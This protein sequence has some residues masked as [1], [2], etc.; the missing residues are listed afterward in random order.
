[1]EE[2]LQNFIDEQLKV[3]FDREIASDA[4]FRFA[5]HQVVELVKDCYYKSKDK[6]ITSQYFYEMYENLEK[7][8]VEVCIWKYILFVTSH[9]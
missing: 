8:L 1:M 9:I 7:L 5:H 6:L 3:E 2:K 4:V